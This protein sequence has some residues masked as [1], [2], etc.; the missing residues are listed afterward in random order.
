MTP[1]FRASIALAFLT[2]GLSPAFARGAGAPQPQVPSVTA[3]SESQDSGVG[4]RQTADWVGKP[5]LSSDRKPVG[6]LRAVRTAS[7]TADAGLLVVDRTGG[8]TAEIPMQGAS[9]DGTHVVVTP[10]LQAIVAN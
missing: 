10:L 6:T 3:E 5:V 7:D 8:G 1:P 9:F 4:D 2:L